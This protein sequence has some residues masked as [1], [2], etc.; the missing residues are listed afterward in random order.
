MKFYIFLKIVLH[1]NIKNVHFYIDFHL[2]NLSEVLHV[3]LHAQFVEFG[4]NT[5]REVPFNAGFVQDSV[6]LWFFGFWS[7]VR[8]C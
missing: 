2:Y 5:S 1:A 3:Y 6:L 4:C 7:S 8:I